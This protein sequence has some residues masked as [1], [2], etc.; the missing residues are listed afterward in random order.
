VGRFEHE[1]FSRAMIESMHGEG[2]LMRSDGAE[3]RF[4]RD[5]LSDQAVH[6]LAGSAIPAVIG[7]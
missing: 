7:M 4:F 5:V 6:V 3:A 1:V 2:D